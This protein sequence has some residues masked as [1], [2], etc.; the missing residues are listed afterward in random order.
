MMEK[1]KLTEEEHLAK[2]DQAVECMKGMLKVIEV[3]EDL[4]PGVIASAI[5]LVLSEIML[6][7]HDSANAYLSATATCMASY[8]ANE[9]DDRIQNLKVRDVE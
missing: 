8:M 5:G 7:S 6:V 3:Y 4:G 1:K 9:K 2:A